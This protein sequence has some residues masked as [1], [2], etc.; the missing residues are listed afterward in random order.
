MAL[1]GAAPARYPL[2]GVTPVYPRGGA[3]PRSLVPWPW[4]GTRS[5]R[6]CWRL[7][8]AS[9]GRAAAAPGRDVRCAGMRRGCAGR[10]RAR[11]VGR[12]DA[13]GVTVAPAV[14]PPL[15]GTLGTWCGGATCGNG[16]RG[17]GARRRRGAPA[18]KGRPARP[19]PGQPGGGGR[20]AAGPR[21]SPG[22]AAVV[23]AERGREC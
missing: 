16:G 20:P 7:N 8:R 9:R 1:G 14:P 2:P 22:P 15:P 18:G 23:T 11:G 4:C 3:P 10:A 17:R 6:R 13:A 5:G 19:A 21:C 12:D